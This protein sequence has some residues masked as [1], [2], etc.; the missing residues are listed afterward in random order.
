[1]PLPYIGVAVGWS[2]NNNLSHEL[3]YPE[4][5]HERT[6]KRISRFS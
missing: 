2:V 4:E 3:F 5:N 1:M 6:H